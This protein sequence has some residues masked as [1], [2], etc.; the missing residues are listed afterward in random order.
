MIFYKVNNAI[1]FIFVFLV[2]TGCKQTPVE[3]I[4]V[5]NLKCELLE[6][7]E[8]IDAINPRLSWNLFSDQRNI[9]QTA[10]QILVA[11]TPKILSASEGDLWNSGKIFSNQS[12]HIPY[13]GTKLKSQMRC[14]WKVKVWSKKGESNWSEP[15]YWSVGLLNYKDWKGRWI[16]FDR[17]FPWD[18]VEK[19]SRLSARYF[20][21]EFEAKENTDIERATVYIIGLGLYELYI[22]GKKIGDQVLAPAPT[23]YTKNV[24]YNTFDVTEHLQKGHNAIGTI[25]GNGRYFTM[26]QNYKPYKIK[27]FGFPKM[28]LNL[29]I[30]YS[31]GTKEV[32]KTDNSW[33]GTAD[34]PIRSNNEYDGEEYDARKEMPG[35]NKTGFDDNNWLNVEYVQEPGGDYESQMNENMKVMHIIKPVSI[36]NL[37]KNRFILDFGQNMAGWIRM[38]VKGKRGTRVK[39]RFGESLRENVELFVANLRDAKATDIYTL[40][41]D[42]EEI[43]EP[44]FVYHGFKFV[45]ISGYPDKPDLK[46]FK[47]CVVYDNIKT[48]GTFESSDS[49]INQI[50]KNAFWSVNSSYKGMPV[51]CPQRNERMPW[52][53]DRAIGC[54]GESFLLDNSRLYL[55]WLDDIKNSQKAD[56]SISDVAPPYFRYYSDNMTWPGTYLFVTDMLYQQYGL[57]DPIEE[58]YPY[59]KKWL[60]YMKDQYLVDFILTK[61]SYGDWCAPHKTIEE[62][63]GK[64]ADVKRPSQLISTAYFYCYL[65]LM[66]KFADLSGNK[67]DMPEYQQLAKKVRIAFNNKFF[68][69]DSAYYGSNSLTDNLLPLYFEMIPEESKRDV[70]ENIRKIIMTEN[71]GHLSTGLVGIQWLM[72]SLAENGMNDI[73]FRLAT[74]TT[75]PSWGYMIENGA[76]TIWE[77]W[78]A[79]TAAPNMNSQNHVMLLGDLII[80]Y[81]ENLAGIKSGNEDPGF[82]K[83]ILEPSF[84]NNLDY[85]NASYTSIYGKIESN[86]SRKSESISWEVTIPANTAAEVHFPVNSINQIYENNTPVNSSTGINSNIINKGKTILEIGSG[87]YHFT[88]N[89]YKNE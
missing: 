18:K 38:K 26:R 1:V 69:K 28:L 21:K 82:K 47:A 84:I 60:M 87:T 29:V 55:K 48:T 23:D 17:A 58:H 6:N 74:N 54:Y 51:D 88:I 8:G 44:S 24:K 49:L 57:I 86:W 77:L 53:G 80:W 35:W 25:L 32:I 83:I 12:I 19:F 70:L 63:R 81:F 5:G 66:Q 73:G 20:R 4:H 31:D 11:S 89:N 61:D 52:L 16:G 45:E 56:G 22:N 59:M 50:F 33:K 3:Q 40:T 36:T 65:Q 78:N 10:Y 71:S 46:N 68:N 64:S 14:Y 76:T 79:N 67:L 85:V 9:N 7:P 42:G 34:G 39:L 41:G 30:E 2:F 75:Y 43:W 13:N 27:T 37:D 15:A 62:G 72:R